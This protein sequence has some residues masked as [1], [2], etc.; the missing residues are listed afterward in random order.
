MVGSKH[1]DSYGDPELCLIC[2]TLCQKVSWKD[3]YC[4]KCNIE[5]N[6]KT[7]AVFAISAE[8]NRRRLDDGQ[9]QKRIEMLKKRGK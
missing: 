4:F 7:R 5:F 2:G 8:G 1:K 6:V 9:I 3:A